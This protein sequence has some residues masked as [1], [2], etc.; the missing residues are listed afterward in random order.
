MIV[1]T[2]EEW[3]LTTGTSV[4]RTSMLFPRF[5]Q[6]EALTN[7]VAAVREEGVG[8]RWPMSSC[9]TPLL[10][11]TAGSASGKAAPVMA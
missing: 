11:T 9:N 6:W 1:E 3:D 8:Q 2:K 5:H 10:R 4:R 7:I